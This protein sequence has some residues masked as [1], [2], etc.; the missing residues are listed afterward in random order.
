M[1]DAAPTMYECESGFRAGC[2]SFRGLAKTV[3]GYTSM[4]GYT[5]GSEDVVSTRRVQDSNSTDKAQERDTQ[6][7]SELIAHLVGFSE[8]Q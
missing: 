2:L 8:P 4:N 5:A 3:V 7:S 1:R 6:P